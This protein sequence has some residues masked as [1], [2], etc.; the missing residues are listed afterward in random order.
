M[1]RLPSSSP[2]KNLHH[3]SSHL[4]FLVSPIFLQLLYFIIVSLFGFLALKFSKPT[5]PV[6]PSDF[7][8]FFT[9]VSASTVSS[10]SVVEMEAFSNSQLILIT[11]LML[12]GGEVFTSMLALLF[13]SSNVFRKHSLKDTLNPLPLK[14]NPPIPSTHQIE[15]GLVSVHK[16]NEMFAVDSGD[17][18]VA[19]NDGMGR[20]RQ[21][22]VKFL[23]LVVLGYLTVLHLLGSGLVWSYMSIVPSAR[24]VLRN[25]RINMRTFSV[26]TVVS[27]FASCGFVPINEN[28]FVFKQNPG[29]LLLLLPYVFLGSTLY[30][31]FLRLVMW[32]L[33]RVTKREE[34]SYIQKNYEEMGYDHM[35]SGVHC[36][37]LVATVL[38]LN[39]TQLVL[40]CCMEW[41]SENMEGQ[42]SY[43]KLISSLFQI[44]NARHAGES[45]FDLSTLSSATLVLFV[46]MMYLPPYTT[47][48]P[49]R[50]PEND[51]KQK[52]SLKECLVSSQ[53]S[54]LVM[55]IILICITERRSLREDPLNFNVFNITLEV[56]SAY[57]NVGFSMGYS[58][59]R[60]LIADGK[61]REKWVG[62]AGRW[63]N[64]GKLILIVVMIFGRVKKFNINGG[65]AWLL[66]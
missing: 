15:I 40:F 7:D 62:F 63:S 27:T 5:I 17:T 20:L 22:S 55:F 6:P 38:G 2:L 45:V 18:N 4:P 49:I 13:S 53:L 46:V 41:R 61:C 23:G 3:P 14:H 66:S 33:E 10:M 60:Q 19:Q 1:T 29:L 30:P 35:L 16:Q 64:K 43:Q 37:C 9:S 26:F 44:S 28:M 39:L 56:I 21:N 52:I 54:Y 32:V 65:K 8:L 47:F 25:K 57:G 12:L 42:N 48:L 31:P 34:F 50:E 51:R 58:C 59:Q 36:L 24:Q 11:F